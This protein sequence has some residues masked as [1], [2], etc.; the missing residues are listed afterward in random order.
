MLIIVPTPI[1]NLEDITLRALR[2]LRESDIIACE[3][4]RRTLQLLNKYEIK[5]PLVSHHRHNERE[6]ARKL[7]EM[8]E[9]GK[10]VALVSDAGTPGL[11]DPG[12]VLIK[13]TIARGIALD[14]LPGPNALLPALLLSGLAPQPFTFAGF[15]D[16]RAG[17]K[18]K[19]LHELSDI[20]HTLVFY[21]APHGIARELEL[22]REVLGDRLCALSRELSKIHQETIR[23]TLA[24]VAAVAQKRELKGEMALVVEGCAQTRKTPD[25][26]WQAEARRMRSEGIFDKTIANDLASRYAIGRNQVKA[27]LLREEK[28]DDPK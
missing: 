25:G 3:D 6:S 7:I 27:Y 4:T 17:E 26:E 23:G 16:G 9:S 24:E 19:R 2:A 8:M 14:A 5:R 13:E 11:S 10:T 18:R 15:V 12:H 21:V 20:E 28:D 1:G 22:F